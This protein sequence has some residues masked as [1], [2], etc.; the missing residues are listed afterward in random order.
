MGSRFKLGCVTAVLAAAVVQGTPVKRTIG[1][2]FGIPGA[3]ATYDY[4]VVGGGTAGLTIASRLVEQKA[5]S[6][7]VIEAG[8]FYEMS[9]GNLS[10]VPGFAASYVGKS[11]T[12]WQP[13]VDWGYMTTPQAGAN[14][15]TMH[16]PR[17]KI[18]G[19]SSGRNYMIYHRGTV[20]SYQMWADA[21]GDDSYTFDSFLPYLE[22][23]VNFT[24]PNNNLR[25]ANATPE[26][27]VSTLGQKG[28]LSLTFPNF[29]FTFATWATKALEQ[30]GIPVRSG[31]QSG[32]LLGQSYT[33]FTINAE[34]MIRDSSETAFLRSSLDD[35]N[36]TIYH[37]SL[38]KKIIFDGDNTATGVLV[39]TQGAQYSLSARK[40]VILSAGVI[41]SPQLLQ[42]SGVGPA[43]VLNRFSI[44]IVAD[45]PGVGQNM[46]DHIVY[47]ITRRV[48]T[49]TASSFQDSAVLAEQTD[50]FLNE[51]AGM[52]TNPLTDVLA[53]EKIP[54]NLRRE[55]SNRTQGILASEWPADWPEVEYVALSSYLGDGNSPSTADPHDG[56]NYATLT[57]VPVAPR[58]RG[59]VTIL[60]ADVTDPPAIDPAF[61]TDR[62]DV[63]V[64]IAAFKRAREFWSSDVLEDVVVQDA[65]EAYPG[66]QV[67]TD[68]QIEESIRRSFQTIFHGSCT[69]AM[70]NSSDSNAVVDA[71]ARVYGVQNLRVVDAAAFP[72]LPPGH[73]QSHV[74]ALAEKIA[75]DISGNCAKS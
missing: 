26:Y 60:S 29:A 4:V 36:Y 70:G 38:A 67:A 19:G 37:L 24:P 65:E 16:Y 75:C 57:I 44:P 71:Q 40:E 48:N 23:S 14:N 39:D 17:G 1:S 68:A 8:T 73:P 6:V 64:A 42:A 35:P 74:Y 61:L 46:Q 13:L 59:S 62:V 47:G 7:A 25:L 22:K 21:V 72:L 43:D 63:E 9:N 34:T 28:P 11:S 27:D 53:W 58:S 41:G 30:I 18:L 2:S 33:M 66:P 31:F 49:Q 3:N 20:G 56:T 51:A 10:E 15:I 52:L 50:L 12:D 55:M 54:P 5:G 45:R 32:A 69:C